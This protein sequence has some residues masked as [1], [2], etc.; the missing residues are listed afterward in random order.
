VLARMQ[1][2]FF[3]ADTVIHT[4]YVLFIGTKVTIIL[5]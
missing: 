1:Q 3:V 4:T 2:A 5:I